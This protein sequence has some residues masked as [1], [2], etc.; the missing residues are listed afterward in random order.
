MTLVCS[1]P[2]A[3]HSVTEYTE[4]CSTLISCSGDS[5]T[6]SSPRQVF[7]LDRAVCLCSPV[8]QECFI[9]TSE[10][11]LS[12]RVRGQVTVSDVLRQVLSV[13]QSVQFVL[14]T[15]VD[16]YPPLVRPVLGLQPAETG[17]APEKCRSY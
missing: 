11:R 12:V 10:K 8:S 16:N 7:L 6:I 2:P 1:G 15:G 9:C 17:D 5:F 13:T 4:S 3:L 14:N